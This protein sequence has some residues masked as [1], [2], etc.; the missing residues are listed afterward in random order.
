M[1][2]EHGPLAAVGAGLIAILATMVT[3]GSKIT[4]LI[5]NPPIPN[6]SD[7]FN[8][9][10]KDGVN[11]LKPGG[12]GKSRAGNLQKNLLRILPNHKIVGKSEGIG[13]KFKAL[14][15]KH[16]KNEES[17]GDGSIRGDSENSDE[18]KEDPRKKKPTD[19][20][21]EDDEHK[22]PQRASHPKKPGNRGNRI[23]GES[24][25]LHRGSQPTKSGSRKNPLEVKV[26]IDDL[27]EAPRRQ[28][29]SADSFQDTRKDDRQ[30]KLRNDIQKGPDANSILET[31]SFQSKAMISSPAFVTSPLYEQEAQLK[32]EKLKNLQNIMDKPEQLESIGNIVKKGDELKKLD[33]LLR[34]PAKLQRLESLM[35][36]LP[37]GPAQ[38]PDA[39]Q[40]LQTF[41]GRQPNENRPNF[42]NSEWGTPAR[43]QNS[44]FPQQM[45]DPRGFNALPNRYPE[46]IYSRN[47]PM[48]GSGNSQSEYEE[49]APTALRPEARHFF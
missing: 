32:E 1:L 20:G 21:D 23:R 25:S 9:M 14:L 27:D 48:R 49:S 12:D 22:D 37:R 34:D 36:P 31:S 19:R 5:K 3:Y 8:K 11:N 47:F 29:D 4:K 15:G 39:F 10:N 17:D 43:H 33:D 24:E 46:D 44:P 35:E 7:E 13:N 40:Q 38:V 2:K 28:N 41:S 45:N 18:Y 6:I 26:P 42:P 30:K 16:S